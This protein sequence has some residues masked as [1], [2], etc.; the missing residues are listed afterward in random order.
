ML[1]S[2]IKTCGHGP[3]WLKSDSNKAHFIHVCTWKR[4]DGTHPGYVVTM[5][6]LWDTA[7]GISD[8]PS[9]HV[10]DFSEMTSP[11]QTD[12]RH[13]PRKG[14]PQ[15]ALMSLVPLAKV[16]LWRTLQN[17]YATRVFTDLFFFICLDK[18]IVNNTSCLKLLWGQ[19]PNLFNGEIS[20]FHQEFVI[21]KSTMHGA[22][23]S[24]LLWATNLQ[25]WF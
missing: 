2:C 4:M 23:S 5:V 18:F 12:A 11:Y 25:V 3:F 24:R 14:Q 10:G 22:S 6:T 16:K 17:C 9:S 15:M 1:R 21:P 8:Q 20:F 13:S 7:W 19:H